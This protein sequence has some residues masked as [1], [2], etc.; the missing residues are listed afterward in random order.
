MGWP[1]VAAIVSG[2]SALGGM[3]SARKATKAQQAMNEAQRKINRLKN[4]QAKRA[5]LRNFRQQQAMA[6]QR[7]VAAGVGLE[8][9]AFQGQAASLGSQRALGLKEFA[10]MEALGAEYTAA[11]NA[12][13]SRSAQAQRWSTVGSFAQ[14]FISFGNK[15]NEGNE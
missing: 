5:F 7:S 8:S 2:A 14:Q 15:G 4:R 10:Q 12:Y 11:Q 3:R 13:S 9:S 6:L 1:L